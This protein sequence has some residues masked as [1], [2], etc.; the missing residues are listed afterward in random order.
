MSL[1]FAFPTD[2]FLLNKPKGR[3]FHRRTQSNSAYDLNGIVHTAPKDIET[4]I[5]AIVSHHN[6][7]GSMATL[8]ALESSRV[9]NIEKQVI[10]D[11]I[12]EIPKSIGMILSKKSGSSNPMSYIKKRNL[13]CFNSFVNPCPIKKINLLHEPEKLDNLT[14]LNTIYEKRNSLDSFD[15]ESTDINSPCAVSKTHS[16]E[17][18]EDIEYEQNNSD[19]ELETPKKESATERKRSSDLAQE[20]KN[21]FIDDLKKKIS[22]PKSYLN[23]NTS[24]NMSL[25]MPKQFLTLKSSTPNSSILS[26]SNPG[27]YPNYTLSHSKSSLI[28]PQKSNSKIRASISPVINTSKNINI[29]IKKEKDNN[30]CMTS[31]TKYFS[32]THQPIQP[33][34][35]PTNPISQPETCRT[36]NTESQNN[37]KVRDLLNSVGSRRYNERKDHSPFTNQ[38]LFHE[39]EHKIEI[40]AAQVISLNSKSNHLENQVKQLINIVEKL[41]HTNKESQQVNLLDS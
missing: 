25:F 1:G 11:D 37:H 12:D 41:T 10:V 19:N 14:G 17:I 32:I 29:S 31:F 24:S 4:D 38:S 40:L 26:H 34:F 15:P 20:K 2:D 6:I 22:V 16:K 13:S 35:Q 9:G 39:S 28:K 23:T 18:S 5:E 3:A 33:V 8:K 7:V 27:H 21:K 36:P 30:S